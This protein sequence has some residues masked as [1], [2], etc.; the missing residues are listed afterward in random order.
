[1][2][3]FN[4]KS[5]LNLFA[6]GVRTTQL[7]NSLF[8]VLVLTK[9][10][11]LQLCSK[12]DGIPSLK[13]LWRPTLYG[14]F[15]FIFISPE[16]IC[17]GNIKSDG[18]KVKDISQAERGTVILP[19]VKN[20]E[21]KLSCICR[22]VWLFKCSNHSPFDWQLLSSLHSR[23]KTS[24]CSLALYLTQRACCVTYWLNGGC[25]GVCFDSWETMVYKEFECKSEGLEHTDNSPQRAHKCNNILY[26]EYIM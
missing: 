19:P 25:H 10:E 21:F 24:L 7:L 20:Q 13:S 1:M 12:A 22:Q 5:S 16:G 3:D 6:R 14:F 18:R 4:P 17:S 11:Q 15:Y 9:E 23:V 8:S 2:I 26:K